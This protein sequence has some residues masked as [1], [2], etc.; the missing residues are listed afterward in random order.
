MRDVVICLPGITGSVLKKDGRDV[1]NVSG[2]A[3]V[4][5][6]VESGEERARW[7]LTKAEDGWHETELGPLPAGVYRLTVLGAEP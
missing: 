1:W 4:A 2:G 6:E 3:L 5:V 7:P